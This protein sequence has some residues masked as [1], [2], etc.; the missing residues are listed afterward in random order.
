MRLWAELATETEALRLT[1][2]KLKLGLT[3]AHFE[4][5]AG[6]GVAQWLPPGDARE[7]HLAELLELR[8]ARSDLGLLSLQFRAVRTLR[9]RLM[10]LALGLQLLH[11]LK[12]INQAR[13]KDR[14]LGLRSQKLLVSLL[15]LR[16]LLPRKP[17]VCLEVFN[18]LC[19]LL[20]DL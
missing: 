1:H 9:H 3:D 7:E 15:Q 8:K 11:S 6:L 13:L 19:Q 20:E 16:L 5:L 4:H 17:E 14:Q 12:C 18:A 2:P 10:L